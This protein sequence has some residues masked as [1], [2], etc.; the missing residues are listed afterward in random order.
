MQV[1]KVPASSRDKQLAN[2]VQGTGQ[3]RW[4]GEAYSVKPSQQASITNCQ[5]Y[6][7]IIRTH[8]IGQKAREIAKLYK[9]TYN[10][11]TAGNYCINTYKTIVFPLN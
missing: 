11:P 3:P 9:Y 5:P 7:T 2:I 4:E 6:Q 1:A 8:P 10:D